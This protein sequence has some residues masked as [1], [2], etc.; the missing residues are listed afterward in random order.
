MKSLAFTS[1]AT[2]TL[3][4]FQQIT[5]DAKHGLTRKAAANQSH[6]FF[7]WIER[8]TLSDLSYRILQMLVSGTCV[9]AIKL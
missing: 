4:E 5:Y 8:Q 3:S 6:S 9:A 2:T 1:Q 7:A